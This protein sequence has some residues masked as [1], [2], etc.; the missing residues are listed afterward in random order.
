VAWFKEHF[1]AQIAKRI[2]GTPLT[3]RFIAAL[4]VSESY[5]LWGQPLPPMAIGDLLELCVGDVLDAPRRHVFPGTKADLLSEPNGQEMF[6][7]ARTA[8]VN[9]SKYNRAYA[10]IAAGNPDKFAHAFGVF[11]YDLQFY[12]NYPDFFLQRQWHDFDKSLDL[13]MPLLLKAIARSPGNGKAALAD[14]EMIYVG[15]AWHKGRVDLQKGL[16]Q[17][18]RDA[19]GRYYGESL[20]TYLK[21]AKEIPDVS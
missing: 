6:E 13:A 8:L 14:D 11:S 12:K 10:A 19:S 3:P 4:A 15:I 17:G 21:I 9:T 1:S 16:K 18:V 5:Y 2:A 7:I 20:M